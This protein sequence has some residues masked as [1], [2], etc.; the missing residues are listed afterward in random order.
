MN[1]YVNTDISLFFNM[2]AMAREWVR[3][4]R[5]RWRRRAESADDSLRRALTM[6]PGLR[7][8]VAPDAGAAETDKDAIGIGRVE[9]QARNEHLV[10]QRQPIGKR[11]EGRPGVMALEEPL[12]PEHVDPPGIAWIDGQGIAGHGQAAADLTPGRSPIAARVER[13]VAAEIEV[14]GVL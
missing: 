4:V 8:C 9:G 2:R 3:S 14:R 13:R 10:A 11:R 12:A 1:A 6:A 5:E 7:G